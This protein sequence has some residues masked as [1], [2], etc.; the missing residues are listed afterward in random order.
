MANTA[1]LVKEK[2]FNLGGNKEEKRKEEEKEDG[3]SVDQESIGSQK[4]GKMKR[5][6]EMLSKKLHFREEEET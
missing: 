6:K 4:K 2:L 3:E 5:I 1:S